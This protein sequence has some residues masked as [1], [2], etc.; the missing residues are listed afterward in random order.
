MTGPPESVGPLWYNDWRQ[1]ELPPLREFRPELPV[2]VIVPYYAQLEE[3]GRTLAALERQ[4]WPRDLFEV[5]VVGDGSPEPLSEVGRS[6]IERAP[7]AVRVVRQEDRGFGLARARNTGARAAAHEVLLFLDGDMLPE[8][9]WLLAHARWHHAAPEALTLGLRAHVSVEGVDAA[10]IRNRP[11]TLTELFADRSMDRTERSWVESHLRR[12]DELT[13]TA[14][15]LFQVVARGNFGIRRG[16]YGLVGGFDES[17]TEWGGEDTEFGYRAFTRGGLFVPVRDAFAWHQGSWEDG[18]A[19]KQRSQELARAKLAHLVAHPRFRS[20]SQGRVFTVPRFVVT[21]RGGVLPAKDLLKVVE[22]VLRGPPHDL[23]VRLELPADHAGRAWLECQLGP[24]PRVRVAPPCPALLEFPAS[25]FQV[26]LPAERRLAR[27]VV[28]RLSTALGTA[29]FGRCVFPDGSRASIARAWALHRAQRTSWEAADFGEVVTIPPGD[30]ES[31]PAGRGKTVPAG[32]AAAGPVVRGWERFGAEF[33]RIDGP[34]AAW[35]FVRWI[36]GAVLR[37]VFRRFR[38][39][40]AASVAPAARTPVSSPRPESPLGVEIAALGPRSRRVFAASR[41]VARTLV[42]QSVEVALA[43]TAAEAAGVPAPVVVLA[44]AP[45]QLSVPALDPVEHNPIGWLRHFEQTVGALGPRSQL[46]AGVRADCEVSPT[47]EERIRSLHH[48]VDVGAFHADPVA[49]AATLARLAAR[50]TV[51]RLADGGPELK[52]LL[53]AE[54]HGLLVGAAPGPEAG[55]R[56]AQ[57]IRIRRAALRAHS[58]GSR[59]R[60]L[61]AAAGVEG[62]P[63]PLVSV[64]L[65]T[66]RPAFLAHALAGVGRQTWPRVELVLGLHGGGFAGV[67]ERLSGFRFPATVVRIGAEEP[68]GA[69]LDRAAAAARGSLLTKMDDDDAY[70]REHLSDLV[71]AQEYSRADLVAKTGEFRYLVASGVTVQNYRGVSEAYGV[72]GAGGTMLMPREALDRMGGFPPVRRHVDLRLF[73]RFRD[74][75]GR[76]YRTHGAGFALVR[77]GVGH[78]WEADDQWFLDRAYGVWPGWDPERAHLGD[79]APSWLPGFG[80]QRR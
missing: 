58:L 62:P 5:V 24:D 66:K 65:V 64:L 30:L 38:S 78:T 56:E 43:D 77:H 29:V 22:R 32:G 35:R 39:A 16:F 51:V 13:S 12:T 60:Q 54:L 14:D 46:P 3:L 37:R 70:G 68:F 31:A 69:A 61:R 23:V 6:L 79:M 48:L 15:D 17:F 72:M 47:D 34:R 53:G 8:A 26:T 41:G 9:G 55:A 20:E 57:S 67:E 71:L 44:E 50:G 1:V 21:I 11:G 4:T 25:P 10:A 36:G 33:A 76:I 28:R 40:P 80:E 7:F 74:S 63:L 75:G 49:R 73:E 27:D 45:P 18:R 52:D 59:A 2:S 42:G 19:A